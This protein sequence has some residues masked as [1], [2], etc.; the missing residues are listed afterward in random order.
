VRQEYYYFPPSGR[1]RYVLKTTR[2]DPSGPRPLLLKATLKASKHLAS[3]AA[4]STVN[5][6]TKR[7]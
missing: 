6:V 1:L 5:G 7:A 4:L 2:T 3:I